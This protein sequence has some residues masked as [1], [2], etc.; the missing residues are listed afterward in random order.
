MHEVVLRFHTAFTFLAFNAS[1]KLLHENVMH[2]AV[3]DLTVLSPIQKLR[4]LGLNSAALISGSVQHNGWVLLAGNSHDTCILTPRFA[5]NLSSNLFLD[6]DFYLTSLAYPCCIAQSNTDL[7]QMEGTSNRHYVE[8]AVLATARSVA[9][10][11]LIVLVF[12]GKLLKVFNTI[13]PK[14]IRIS[15]IDD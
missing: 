15:R 7:T 3:N 13:L 14:D 2:V 10:K 1:A 5:I 12:L 4:H 9:R 11:Q 8:N 6:D